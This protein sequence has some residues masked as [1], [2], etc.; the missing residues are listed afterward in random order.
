V[1]I[2]EEFDAILEWATANKMTV[3]M[4]KAKEIVFRHPN[5]KID[6]HLS[7]FLNI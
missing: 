4:T 7:T 2:Q 3:I 5:P 6:L 1:Q